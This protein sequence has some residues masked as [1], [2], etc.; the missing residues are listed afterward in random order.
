MNSLI[1]TDDELSAHPKIPLQNFSSPH[2]KK[3]KLLL[4]GSE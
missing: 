2:S 1:L 4:K 3:V